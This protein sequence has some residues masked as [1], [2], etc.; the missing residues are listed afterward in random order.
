MQTVQGY[1]ERFYHTLRHPGSLMN[2]ASN[3]T[4]GAIDTAAQNPQSYL[5]RLR[6]L[7]GATLASGG[8]VVAEIIGFFT[9]GEMLGRLKVIGYRSGKSAPDA[10]VHH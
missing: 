5:Q 6:N 2:Q 10:Q 3:A 4:S 7:D 1:F 9:V 8:V